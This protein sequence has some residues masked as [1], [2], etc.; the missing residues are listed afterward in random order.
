MTPSCEKRRSVRTTI[1]ITSYIF[2]CLATL[3]NQKICLDIF[4]KILLQISHEKNLPGCFQTFDNRTQVST[5]KHNPFGIDTIQTNRAHME[6]TD[7]CFRNYLP[8]KMNEFS[9]N[10]LSRT[11]QYRKISVEHPNHFINKRHMRYIVD[12]VMSAIVKVW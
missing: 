2:K 1:Y 10:T 8:H 11:K 7:N 12:I 4:A 3:L 6:L 5:H 9:C